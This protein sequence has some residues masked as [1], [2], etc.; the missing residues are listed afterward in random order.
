MKISFIIV[1][2]N[3]SKTIEKCLDS[4][5]KQEGDNEIIIIDNNSTDNSLKLIKKYE[6]KSIKLIEKKENLG[7]S[8]GNN[9]GIEKSKGDYIALI[10]NDVTLEKN[11][12]KKMIKR[13]N[14]DSKIGI[15]GCKILY[16]SGRIWFG[17]GKVFFPGFPKHLDLKKESFIDYVAFA[18][19]LIKREALEKSKEENYLDENIFMYG[20]DIELCK[21]IR[22]KGYNILYYPG[23]IAYHHINENRISKNEEYGASRNKSYYFTKFYNPINKILFLIGDLILFFPL[24]VGYRLIK[25]P[26]R[27]K[28]FK[29]ILKARIDSIPLML[30]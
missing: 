10:N 20:E 2:Y 13:L 23:A 12:I 3:G 9:I 5:L 14:K 28:F 22:L 19:C 27:I 21:R 8:K 25:N 16:P 11:W 17:G 29:S 24:F 6:N 18:A 1:N 26:K 4:V 15:I 7:F 30:K